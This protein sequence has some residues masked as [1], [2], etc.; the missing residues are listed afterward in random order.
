LVSIV[1]GVDAVKLK[2]LLAVPRD[3]GRIAGE[4]VGQITAQVVARAL[5]FLDV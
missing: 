4:F 3:V 5:D 2:E 1:L